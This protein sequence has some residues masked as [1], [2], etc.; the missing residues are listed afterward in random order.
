MVPSYVFYWLAINL[1]LLLV[2]VTL[3]PVQQI[4]S[5]FKPSCQ[6]KSIEDILRY[7]KIS[8]DTMN[9]LDT[10]KYRFSKKFI[11]KCVTRP[12]LSGMPLNIYLKYY[13]LMFCLCM[14]KRDRIGRR[15]WKYGNILIFYHTMMHMQLNGKIWTTLVV[16]HPRIIPVKGV[17]RLNYH[18]NKLKLG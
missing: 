18:A 13:N 6:M 14:S 7:H 3:F 8:F 12:D 1:K 11:F 10:R 15:A 16:N 17:H 5:N 2:L 9:T 4:H